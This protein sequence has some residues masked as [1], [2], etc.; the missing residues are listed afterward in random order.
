VKIFHDPETLTTDLADLG[1]SADIRLRV[2]FLV[3]IAEPPTGP[4]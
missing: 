2:N 4:R 1:W 3:G